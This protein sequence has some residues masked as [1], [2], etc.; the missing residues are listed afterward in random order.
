MKKNLLNF[1]CYI[2][3]T[4]SLSYISTRLVIEIYKKSK[5]NRKKSNRKKLIETN[6]NREKIRINKIEKK[7]VTN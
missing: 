1:T 7:S 4:N 6:E 3:I 5:T 2:Q